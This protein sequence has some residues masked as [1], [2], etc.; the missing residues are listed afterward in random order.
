[1]WECNQKKL[2][3]ST[4]KREKETLSELVNKRKRVQEK[5]RNKNLNFFYMEKKEKSYSNETSQCSVAWCMKG[6]WQ[7]ASSLQQVSQD[8]ICP[9]QRSELQLPGLSKMAAL[10]SKCVGKWGAAAQGWTCS[11]G[12]PRD[13]I[14]GWGKSHPETPAG[15]LRLIV[16]YFSCI[17]LLI[18]GRYH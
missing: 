16:R 6:T 15:G 2:D 4:Q 5:Q 11:A 14:F 7:W 9:T 12:G 3:V 8:G 18:T 17:R 10:A 13:R 1:M